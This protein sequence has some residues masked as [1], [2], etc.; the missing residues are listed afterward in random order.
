[1]ETDAQKKKFMDILTKLKLKNQ[2]SKGLY[3]EFSKKKD[4]NGVQNNEA[5]IKKYGV[6][7]T[8]EETKDC[9][10]IVLH[11]W[12]DCTL[13]CGGGKSYLQLMKVMKNSSSDAQ[14]CKTKDSI[15]TR[16][17]NIQPCPTSGAFEKT[18]K[19]IKP[20]E[21]VAAN[22]TVKIMAISSR[23]QRFDKCHLKEGDALMQKKD[24]SVK[25]FT[26]YPLVP[27]RIVMNDK[28]FT[29]YQDDNLENKIATYLLAESSFVRVKEKD[30]CFIIR[31]NVSDDTFCMLDSSKGNF[32]EEWDYDF[33]LFKHQ[34]RKN[35]IKSETE[36]ETKRLATEFQNK[37]EEMKVDLVREKAEKIKQKVG[38]DEKKKFVNKIDQVR[39]TSLHALEKEMKLED[40]LEKEEESKEEEENKTLE[41]QIRSEKKKEDCLL[42]AIKEKEIENQ[43]N[44]AKSQ[45]DRAIQKI[46]QETQQQIILQRKNIALK[47]IEMRQKQKRKKAQLKSEIMTIR[48][49][50]ADKLTKINKVGDRAR[51][52]ANLDKQAYCMQNFSD[53]YIKL[54]ECNSPD[55]FCY[56]CCENEFGDLHIL[57]RDSCYTA[58]DTEKANTPD[59]KAK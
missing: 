26:N 10:M 33:N 41:M 44:I 39:K 36:F 38:Q 6:G 14:D 43:Y 9:K 57:E 56:V 32:V 22:A 17:C 31:N 59:S 8:Y 27:I 46:A 35:R 29:A 7:S 2:R 23:P 3:I 48:T 58:C 42:K 25:E 53:N 4:V 37:V 50:I 11:D 30:T 21:M 18:S 15:L 47:L 28:T 49:Q 19:A 1:M 13:S 5:A 34:C 45:A 52:A 54:G 24:D 51:C 16:D 55:S 20:A 40:L 12:S